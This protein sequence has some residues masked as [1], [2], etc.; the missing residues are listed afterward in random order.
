MRVGGRVDIIIKV[1]PSLP[2]ANPAKLSLAGS[3]KLAARDRHN[4]RYGMLQRFMHRQNTPHIA[5]L[6]TQVR[7]PEG[8]SSSVSFF[9]QRHS[10][11]MASLA[12]G[13][14]SSD[15]KP[16]SSLPIE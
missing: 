2:Q 15:A 5:L 3:H 11:A 6:R 4:R 16:W 7:S 10:I 12:S 9:S 8:S 1:K 14:A 13:T